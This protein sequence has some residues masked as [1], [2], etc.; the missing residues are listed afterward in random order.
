MFETLS[1]NGW[2]QALSAMGQRMSLDKGIFHWSGRAKNEASI[3]A[4]IGSA[5]GPLCEIID[6]AEG[7]GLFYLPSMVEA[8]KSLKPED[9]AAYA[10][11]GGLP[12]FQ[13]QWKQW[14]VEKSATVCRVDAEALS[15][16]M[17]APGLTGGLYLCASLFL[18]P[19]QSIVLADKRWENYDTLFGRN[20]GLN[21]R[22]HKLFGPEG[23]DYGSLEE[24][25][26]AVL[27]TQSHAVLVLNF[28]NNPTGF[29]PQK[30]EMEGIAQVL[31]K[32]AENTGQKV[33]VLC[34]DAYEGFVFDNKAAK[35]S[36][37]YLLV[38]VHENVIPIKIDGLSKEFL[39]YGARVGVVTA[40]MGASLKNRQQHAAD[41]EDKLGG[42]I[43][44]TYS[45]GPRAQQALWLAAM[46]DRPRVM[47]ERD[48][49]L[50][51]LRGRCAALKAG[52][53]Q[54][55]AGGSALKSDPFNSGFFA[56]WNLPASVPAADLADRLLK[57]YKTG[58][59][60]IS[61]PAEGV[62]GVRV[63]FCSAT[64]AQMPE[65]VQ[66]VFSAVKEMTP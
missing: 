26:M 21:I 20:L 59:I 52:Y 34:D 8:M 19:G 30:F 66:N 36:P 5:S 46:K 49:V 45:N 53:D 62:N 4:T 18:N 31:A 60:P 32:V 65:L 24:S 22:S 11:I 25:L 57:N 13:D 50:S 6:G 28:P 38:G 35:G 23:L 55:A 12:G 29:M 47:A 40:G 56:L 58:V 7:R 10:P 48:R 2:A 43:R 9:L 42:L 16:P 51:V 64:E 14:I 41:W 44:A 33:V 63:A 1:E 54:A 3:D 27:K 37:F 39:L 15:K 61:Q 17:V